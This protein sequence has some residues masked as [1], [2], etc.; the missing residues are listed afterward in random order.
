[1]NS[2]SP[3]RKSTHPL[4]YVLLTFVAFRLMAVLLVKPGGYITDVSD[5]T[6]YRLLA[7]YASQGFY[8]SVHYWM[9]YPPLFPW[10]SVGI[11]Q[12]SLLLPGWAGPLELGDSEA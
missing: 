7:S 5:F 12:L 1:M 4:V 11:Y 3:Q 9:E 2:E 8:P 10:I 6:F